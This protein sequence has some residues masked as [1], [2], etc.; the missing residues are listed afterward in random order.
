[1]KLNKKQKRTILIGL[2]VIAAA[3]VVWLGFGSEIFTKTQV[4]VEKKDELFGT[5]YKEFEDRFVLGLDYTG[6]F[7]FAV[8]VITGVIAFFQ[9]SRKTA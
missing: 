8:F 7:S 6:A 2:L 1:M 3:I 4:I 5:T 9:R